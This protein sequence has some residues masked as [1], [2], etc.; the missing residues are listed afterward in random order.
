MKRR[1]DS[2][3]AG[4]GAQNGKKRKE[5]SKAGNKTPQM[6][7]LRNESLLYSTSLVELHYQKL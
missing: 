6:E 2:A 5:K 7:G 3:A 4:G 1:G